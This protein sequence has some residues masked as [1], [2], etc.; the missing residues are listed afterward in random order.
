MHINPAFT[1]ALLMSK[2]GATRLHVKS[3]RMLPAR[4]ISVRRGRPDLNSATEPS[5]QYLT[6]IFSKTVILNGGDSV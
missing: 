4:S 3:L 2:Q 5:G 6:I 1:H